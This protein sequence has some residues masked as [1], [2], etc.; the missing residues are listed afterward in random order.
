[1]LKVENYNLTKHTTFKI[2][3]DA[4]LVYIPESLDEFVDVLK[5]EHESII[6]GAGS[7]VIISSAGVK[8][9][10]VLTKSLDC[11]NIDGEFVE[12]DCGVK[13]ALL[14]RKVQEYGLSGMEFLCC[15][16]ASVGG[17]V[18]MNASAHKQAIE[19]IIVSVKLFN[20]QTLEVEELSKDELQ[21][22]YRSSII[23]GNYVVLSVRFKLLK[24]NK[25]LILKRMQENKAYRDEKHP[26]M[27][28]PNAGSIFK[29]PDGEIA[30]RLIDSVDLKGFSCGGAS[31]SDVHANFIVN[32]DNANSY[33][34]LSLMLEIKEKVK[35]KTGYN[36]KP[37]VKYIGD[38]SDK[39]REIWTRLNS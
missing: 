38:K 1:M 32:N 37:E 25:D 15:I 6:L 35:Q 28:I 5:K 8:I 13:T 19:D 9:P 7:N 11:F 23:E 14:S 18:T 10:V 34:L 22:D 39:E 3:G 36:L 4:D 20:L 12:A 26:S 31:V 2:G 17:V 29:N 16:P 21:L 24:L 27:K 30:G 33:D